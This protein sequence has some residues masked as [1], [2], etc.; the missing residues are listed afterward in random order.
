MLL[1]PSARRPN[2]GPQHLWRLSYDNCQN[3]PFDI[4]S[5]VCRCSRT[6]ALS[7]LCRRKLVQNHTS[8]PS[9]VSEKYCKYE[10][11]YEYASA[12][13]DAVYVES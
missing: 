10:Y 6:S 2:G 12:Y 13:L 7:L 11:R 3:Q 4:S 8:G 1:H 9:F 5:N